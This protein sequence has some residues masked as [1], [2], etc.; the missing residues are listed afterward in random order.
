MNVFER[1]ELGSS[2]I[3]PSQRDISFDTIF[4]SGRSGS[5]PVRNVRMQWSI[6]LMV[7]HYAPSGLVNVPSGNRKRTY[8]F[9]TLN[10]KN[11]QIFTY[12]SIHD[13]RYERLSSTC[14]PKCDF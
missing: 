13:N 11:A 1:F 9:F 3:K 2:R 5:N 10:I 12:L 4:D 14:S 6:S 8:I 7:F